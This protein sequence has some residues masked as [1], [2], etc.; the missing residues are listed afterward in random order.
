MTEKYS[1]QLKEIGLNI[2][3]YRKLRGYSQMEFASMLGIS[4]T[5]LSN[6][7][8]PKTKTSLSLDLLFKISDALK[9]DIKEF[10]NFIDTK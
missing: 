7:E 1:Q 4:R 9:I 6:I 8:A 2:A 3:H 5:H 10:F